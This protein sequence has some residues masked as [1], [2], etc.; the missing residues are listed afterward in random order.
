[1]RRLARLVKAMS[2]ATSRMGTISTA[3]DTAVGHSADVSLDLETITNDVRALVSQ[4]STSTDQ[5]THQVADI[6]DIVGRIHTA[7]YHVSQVIRAIGASTEQLG[8]LLEDPEDL[9]P[10]LGDFDVGVV[11][12]A[13]RAIRSINKVN[14]STTRVQSSSESIVNSAEQLFDK[15]LELNNEVVA[16]AAKLRQD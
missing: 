6:Q 15:L 7:M 10:E 4:T 8:V 16:F 11:D 3:V 2:N 1:M 14:K 5:I 12:A 13:H 9:S